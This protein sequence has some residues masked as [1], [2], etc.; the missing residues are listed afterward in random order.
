MNSLQ[1]RSNFH[2]LIDNFQNENVLSKFYEILSKSNESKDGEL[3]SRLTVSEQ[4]ELINISK[5]AEDQNNLISN[6]EMK[7]K[8]K[9][10]L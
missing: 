4:E 9:K 5:S 10:W 2:A 8:Y 7:Q 1:L 6:E 3:W